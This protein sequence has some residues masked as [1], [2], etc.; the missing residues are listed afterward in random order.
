MNQF[1]RETRS[2]DDE[3]ELWKANIN[4]K[5]DVICAVSEI[6]SFICNGDDEKLMEVHVTATRQNNAFLTE[7]TTTH[8]RQ[9]QFQ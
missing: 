7:T 1:L 3:T 6:D 9:N 2:H 5:T 4:F 8:V